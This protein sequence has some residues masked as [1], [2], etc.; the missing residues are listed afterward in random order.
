MVKAIL[1]P[2]TPLP[3]KRR[4]SPKSPISTTATTH[5]HGDFLS[6]LDH[7]DEE[8][9]VAHGE[10]DTTEVKLLYTKVANL[11]LREYKLRLTTEESEKKASNL[12][13]KE[14][15]KLNEEVG[16]LKTEVGQ[17]KGEV[18]SLKTAKKK[19]F[20][21]AAVEKMVEEAESNLYDSD[22]LEDRIEEERNKWERKR[23]RKP[24]VVTEEPKRPHLTPA[25]PG[26]KPV[27]YLRRSKK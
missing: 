10:G 5:G 9:R 3:N 1:D 17:L 6:L 14:A 4:R 16:E 23:K 2:V 15:D 20:T 26:L 27:Q 8:V 7:L 25:D 24:V 18:E 22:E 21:K 13:Q 12:L 11:A 19:M